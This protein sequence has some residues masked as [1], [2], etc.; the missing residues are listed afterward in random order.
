MENLLKYKFE[1]IL[2]GL[3]QGICYLKENRYTFHI[4]SKSE[5]FIKQKYYD[6]D[7]AYF[8]Q[9]LDEDL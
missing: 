7:T 6:C 2:H 9:E 3:F 5:Y 4:Q 1:A 8:V